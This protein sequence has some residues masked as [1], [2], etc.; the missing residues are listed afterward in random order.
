MNEALL[1]SQHETSRR[2]WEEPAIVLER[3]LEVRA[4]VKLPGSNSQDP[5]NLNPLNGFLGPLSAS[6]GGTC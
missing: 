1:T 2:P 4:Q 6:G 3:S 5:L